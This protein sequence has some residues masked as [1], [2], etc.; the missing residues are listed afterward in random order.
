MAYAMRSQSPNNEFGG[1]IKLIPS[2]DNE[3]VY[4]ISLKTNKKLKCNQWKFELYENDENGK[5]KKGVAVPVSELD[6]DILK[7][8]L[9]DMQK[10]VLNDPFFDLLSKD[11][12]YVLG[13]SIPHIDLKNEITDEA[14]EKFI[15]AVKKDDEEFQK[16]KKM[17]GIV[18]E[19]LEDVKDE[20][21][22][23][24]E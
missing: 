21:T 4:S 20:E 22:D 11:G 2:C 23:T 19:L 5:P 13:L 18:K 17:K 10:L 15:E 8:S 1:S 3:S 6:K 9:L 16:E 24:E 14:I 12:S 7:R